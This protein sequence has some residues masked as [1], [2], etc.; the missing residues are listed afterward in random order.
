MVKNSKKSPLFSQTKKTKKQKKQTK[1][2][3]KK[4]KTPMGLEKEKRKGLILHV[5]LEF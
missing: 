5:T 4:K 2:Y 3:K 1:T